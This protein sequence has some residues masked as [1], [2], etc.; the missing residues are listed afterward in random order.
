[1]KRKIFILLILSINLVGFAQKTPSNVI[2]ILQSGNSITLTFNLPTYTIKDT[3]LY[4]PYGIAEIFKYIDIDYFGS[5]DDIGYPQLPQLTVD[6]SVPHGS[7]DFQ[8]TSSNV[9]TQDV[10]VNRKILPTQEDF[11][12]NPNF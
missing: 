2:S 7:S 3:S 4:E 8:V 6:L 12:E 5:I 11:E 1:M 9:V 10:T